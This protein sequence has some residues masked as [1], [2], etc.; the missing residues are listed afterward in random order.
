MLRL[1]M[2]RQ[3]G[4]KMVL[5]P[6]GVDI[7]SLGSAPAGRQPHASQPLELTEIH[8]FTGRRSGRKLRSMRSV[9][10]QQSIIPPVIIPSEY[11]RLGLGGIVAEYLHI[12]RPVVYSDH[13]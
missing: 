6:E 13:S 3:Q 10:P 11:R 1:K 9:G 2:L 4:G 12:L 7:S 8:Q 5:E